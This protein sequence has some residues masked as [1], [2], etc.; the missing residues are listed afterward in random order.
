MSQR[1]RAGTQPGPGLR[2]SLQL[3]TNGKGAP[4]KFVYEE[5]IPY[6]CVNPIYCRDDQNNKNHW[7]EFSGL[8]EPAASIFVASHEYESLECKQSK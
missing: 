7:N 3:A 1:Y 6:I 4:V 5:A 8:A 2:G